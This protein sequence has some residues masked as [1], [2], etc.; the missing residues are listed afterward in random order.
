MK[1]VE[2]RYEDEAFPDMFIDVN[3]RGIEYH[4]A[5]VATSSS[6]PR[7]VE[8]SISRSKM[9]L[10]DNPNCYPIYLSDFI[11]RR[12]REICR[13]FDMGYVDL[14]GN[15]FI[16]I[17]GLH[18]EKESARAFSRESKDL[19]NLFSPVST[20]IIRKILVGWKLPWTTKS[21][22]ELTGASIGMT[23]K[24]VKKLIDMKYI[25]RDNDFKLRIDEPSRLL[26]DWSNEYSF[27]VNKI[28]P[29]YSFQKDQRKL[30]RDIEKVSKNHDLKYA[31]TLHSG[32][33]LVAPYVRS[34]E[35]HVYVDGD[36][37]IWIDELDLRPVDSG[38][39]INLVKPYDQGVLDDLQIM[40]G[41]NVVSNIQLYL[42]L[43][44]YPK[45]GKEQADVI[46]ER[47]IGF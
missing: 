10:S 38:G 29:L 14:M 37:D 23:H 15:I 13:E 33:R 2:I 39:N 46:R 30:L 34:N 18:I 36:I 24:V 5:I 42:D 16:S 26:D 1:I 4:L 44:N 35:I 40:D 27:H 9:A 7:Y 20:R 21:L 47:K 12:S 43:C 45:R 25:D 22:S 8:Q 41:L 3:H 28:I 11:G 17:D 19:K 32:G 31:L 6:E